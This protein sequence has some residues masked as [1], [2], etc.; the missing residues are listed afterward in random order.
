METGF[1]AIFMCPLLSLRQFPT[2]TPTP[3]VVIW[4]YRWLIFRIMLGAVS[5]TLY[6][7]VDYVHVVPL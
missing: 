4:G 3:W 2:H 6:L 1:L 5:L 7:I